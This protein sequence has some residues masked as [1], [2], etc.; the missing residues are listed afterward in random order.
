[1]DES[2]P[3]PGA[4]AEIARACSPRVEV[5]GERVVVFDA[6]GLDRII[7]PP[8]MIA[9]EVSALAIEQGLVVR[10]AMAP[11]MAARSH[12]RGRAAGVLGVLSSCC[13][14]MWS[15]DPS[16]PSAVYRCKRPS[17]QISDVTRFLARTHFV[18]KRFSPILERFQA[19][20]SPG[21]GS[22]P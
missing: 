20:W 7:G 8:A 21:P 4:L 12:P 15:G 16:S 17:L 2:P 14:P 22:G 13:K 5:H 11:T 19:K 18:R 1:M 10:I 6:S 3:K 9:R